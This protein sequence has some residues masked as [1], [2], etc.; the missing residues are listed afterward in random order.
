MEAALKVR[1][2]NHYGLW[3]PLCPY[4]LAETLG[5]EVRFVDISRMEGMYSREPAA[6]FVSSLRPAG[7][8]SFTCAHELGHHVFKHGA[9]IDEIILDSKKNDDSEE[10]LADCFAGFLLMSKS[11]VTR[12]FS[13]RNWDIASCTPLQLYV[14]AGWLGVGYTT[15]IH[16]MSATLRLLSQQLSK[17]LQKISPKSIRSTYLGAEVNEELT[18]VDAHWSERAI[19]IQV[20]DLIHLPSGVSSEGNCI[21]LQEECKSGLLFCGSAPGLGRFHNLSS[22]WSAY[23][24]VSRRDYI[25]R[26]IFRHLEDEPDD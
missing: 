8:Q 10:F 14:V 26:S 17:N 16:H 23:V 3:S 11:A 1:R 22:G 13:V 18:I 5:V 4:D 21:H 6:I 20:G 12:A 9:R 19:D 24:R 15:L 7:R 25:G 2:S